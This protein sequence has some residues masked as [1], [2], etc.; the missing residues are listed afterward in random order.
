MNDPIEYAEQRG[1]FGSFGGRYV[2]EPLWTP[3]EAVA[4][5]YRDAMDDEDYHRREGRWRQSRLGR[6]TPLTHLGALSSEIGGAQLW[7]KREDLLDGGTF[8]ITSALTQALIAER[9]EKS[10]L[11]GESAT[12]D[13]G[14]ALGS[15]GA[16]LGLDVT[17][18]MRRAAIEQERLNAARMRR[19]GVEL[20]AVDA[21][22]RG[23]SQAMAEALRSYSISWDE[24]FYATSSLA[25]PAPYPQMVGRALSVIGEECKEQLRDENI[26]VEYAIAPVGSGSFA[27]GLFEALLDDEGPQIIGAQAG[28]GPETTRNSASLVRGRPGVYLGTHSLVLQDDEGQ[29]LAAHAEAPGLV[30]PVAGPQHARWLQEGRV[31]YVMVDDADA[32]QAQRRL[33]RTEGIFASR[34][35]G[36]GL[37]YALKLAPTLRSDQHILVGISGTGIRGLGQ[38]DEETDEGGIA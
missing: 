10:R 22:G 29:I 7:A 23:R 21:A 9:M 14:V 26:E 11:L 37:A 34:E 24:T 25:S 19:L 20:V 31:H 38:D 18:F 4:Q 1:R 12:G 28:G 3:F 30:M 16:A 5:A 33:A 13:F 35:T 8:C 6:P 2:P 17:V 27:A 32:L 15:V 36:Y